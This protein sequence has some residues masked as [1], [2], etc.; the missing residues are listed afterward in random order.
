[1]AGNRIPSGSQD[2]CDWDKEGVKCVNVAV[3]Q[4]SE[5]SSRHV[6]TYVRVYLRTTHCIRE[7]AI[8]ES[9]EGERF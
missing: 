4:C 6:V 9:L 3:I 1:M 5:T 7:T 8:I 2:H